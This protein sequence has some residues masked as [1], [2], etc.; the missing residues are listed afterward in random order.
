MVV[1]LVLLL[2][3]TAAAVAGWWLGSGRFAYAPTVVGLS[4][5]A[6]ETQVRNAGLVPTVSEVS[7]DTVAAG[8]VA[9]ANPGPGTKL[10]RGSAVQVVVSTGRPEVPDIPPG[11]S[12]AR[13]SAMLRESGLR[14]APATT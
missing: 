6:A 2:L 14:T 4:R 7:N 5:S 12:V 1:I 3:A 13:A 9:M 8:T 11:T 10:L